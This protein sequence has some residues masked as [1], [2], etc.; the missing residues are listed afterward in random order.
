M[1]SLHI[2]R[3]E[4]VVG[5]F[6]PSEIKRMIQD[7]T[8]VGTDSVRMEGDADWVPLAEIPALASLLKPAGVKP[9]VPQPPPT[10]T[11][12]SATRP[13]PLDAPPRRKKPRRGGQV[14]EW[15]QLAALETRSAAAPPMLSAPPTPGERVQKP[16]AS[17]RHE[18]G[19]SQLAGG[20]WD[21]A[22]SALTFMFCAG[23]GR[24]A[25]IG[26]AAGVVIMKHLIQLA[27]LGLGVFIPTAAGNVFT[28][29]GNELMHIGL[30]ATVVFSLLVVLLFLTFSRA[31][32]VFRF[33]AGGMLVAIALTAMVNSGGPST[34]SLVLKS[35]SVLAMLAVLCFAL[36]GLPLLASPLE[37]SAKV[38][39]IGS[40][41][42]GLGSCGLAFLGLTTTIDV[43]LTLT[44]PEVHFPVIPGMAVAYAL[45]LSVEI[46]FSAWVLRSLGMK[47]GDAQEVETIDWFLYFHV[48]NTGL[49]LICVYLVNQ[50]VVTNFGG[51]VVGCVATMLGATA[52]I[53]HSTTI[54]YTRNAVR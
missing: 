44:K 34:D 25:V 10:R 27:D 6:S 40:A 5:P 8:I 19:A 35:L 12:S 53:C 46:G 54:L 7:D 52:V 32:E 22:R 36:S 50:G 24:S 48:V 33:V 38:L 20:D 28:F 29:K 43:D 1:A 17:R 49:I 39:L 30:A 3:G 23:V 4:K 51:V 31:P 47:F 26:A 2:R 13:P 11:A 37:A 21:S 42:A 18:G 14:S 9:S 15:D 41:L 16:S 45:V